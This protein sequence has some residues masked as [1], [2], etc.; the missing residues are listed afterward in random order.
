MAARVAQIAIAT[1]FS[2]SY[3]SIKQCK[4]TVPQSYMH[5]VLRLQYNL[6][7]QTYCN[8]QYHKPAAPQCYAPTWWLQIQ[9]YIPTV[10]RS[11]SPTSI[12]GTTNQ[13]SHSPVCIY[14][15]YSCSTISLQSSIPLVLLQHSI[16]QT[17]T[18]TVLYAHRLTM[19]AV[20]YR[21]SPSF[22]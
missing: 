13:H 22:L 15:N 4:P 1:T 3:F 16:L 18:P 11:C 21:Y 19:A 9:Y 7:Q 10:L 20:F 8:S 14:I 17:Y 12:C 6:S 5:T 2:K